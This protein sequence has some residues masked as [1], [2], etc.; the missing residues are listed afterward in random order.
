MVIAALTTLAWILI[1]ALMSQQHAAMALG[2]IPVRFAGADIGFAAVPAFLTP[3]SSAFVHAGV[4][5]LAFNMLMLAWCG[6]AVGL[7]ESP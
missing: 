3:L 1:S 2:F 5:H 6:A 7:D 4:I